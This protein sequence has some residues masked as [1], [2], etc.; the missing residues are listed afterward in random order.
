MAAWIPAAITAGAS[1]IG[2]LLGLKGS[3]DSNKSNYR[4]AQMNNEFNAEQ[5][6]LQYQ[7]SVDLWNMTNEYNTPAN[8]TKRLQ[9]AGLSPYLAYS[10][11]AAGGTAST[12]SAPQAV[13][14]E[15]YQYRSPLEGLAAVIQNIIPAVQQVQLNNEQIKSARTQ[16][17]FDAMSLAHRLESVKYRSFQDVLNFQLNR[18][19]GYSDRSLNNQ[20]LNN[21]AAA[22]TYDKDLA[23]AALLGAKYRNMLGKQQIDYYNQYGYNGRLDHAYFLNSNGIAP[24][25]QIGGRLS[26]SLGNAMGASPITNF[27][28]WLLNLFNTLQR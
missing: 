14:A 27:G 23:S 13:R 20:I 7:R 2:G 9:E 24:L 16:N 4:I 22:S 12:P 5:S 19:F 8:Q 25:L 28:S 3:S 10:N 15:S 6:A 21:R 1:V 18:D 26:Q 17:L 11:G